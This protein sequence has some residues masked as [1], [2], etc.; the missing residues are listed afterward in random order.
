MAV[1]P[2][3]QK[4]FVVTGKEV[5]AD[6]TDVWY[7]GTYVYVARRGTGVSAYSWDGSTLTFVVTQYDGSDFYNGLWGDG[8]H[9]FCACGLDGVRAYT[10]NGS[11][12]TLV[13]THDNGGTYYSVWGDGTSIY[14]ANGN[15]IAYAWNGS[16]FT[17]KDTDNAGAIYYGVYADSSYIYCACGT[18]GVRAYSFDGTT[19]TLIDTAEVSPGGDAIVVYANGANVVY[20][21]N[22]GLYGY[23]FNGSTFINGT[24]TY[25][26]AINGHQCQ[27]IAFD[28]T[29]F[30]STWDDVNGIMAHTFDGTFTFSHEARNTDDNYLGVWADSSDVFVASDN[31]GIVAYDGAPKTVSYNERTFYLNEYLFLGGAWTPWH[32]GTDL[33]V[34]TNTYG[35][36]A[37]DDDSY[38]HGSMQEID[39]I[40]DG[41]EYWSV[42]GDGYGGGTYIYVACGTSGLRAYSWNGSSYALLD[43]VDPGD[44]CLDVWT[45][46]TYVF[47]AMDT[48]GVY[49]YT[50]NGSAFTAA[51]NIDNGDN[52]RSV[53]GDGTYMYCACDVGGIRAYSYNGSAFTLED[54]HVFGTG[55]EDIYGDGT[56]IYVVS[57]PGG[58]LMV[59]SFDGSTLTFESALQWTS[60]TLGNSAQQSVWVDNSFTGEYGV[61][62]TA[63]GFQGVCAYIFTGSS[64]LFL[65]KYAPG[66]STFRGVDGY[67]DIIYA[68]NQ[69][70]VR[71]IVLS[72]VGPPTLLECEQQTNPTNVIDNYPEFSAIYNGRG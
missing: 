14:C 35:L 21:T 69:Q 54:S 18:D 27:G 6:A 41:G 59:Y 44:Q 61:I 55:Y 48:L 71:G 1:V 57:Q 16:A 72:E 24:S 32:D 31:A 3:S 70:Y 29:Y 17:L 12:F 8:T 45:D 15:L 25:V 42:H 4:A 36:Y 33:H 7:D 30:L 53:W 22:I 46:G 58:A 28:G 56:Y 51:G 47:A 39:N 5:V 49:A 26:D 50:F 9:I 64:L 52:Y 10:F 62:Y 2:T 19:L 11:T 43:T 66:G 63:G 40:D 60:E 68:T 34:A 67:G 23:T 38:G 37:I 13:D 65:S 20:G